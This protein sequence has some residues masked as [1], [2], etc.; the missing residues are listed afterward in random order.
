[1]PGETDTGWLAAR[2][3]IREASMADRPVAAQRGREARTRSKSVH[4]PICKLQAGP[5]CQTHL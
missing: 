4:E 3:Q 1:M 2:P 5:S